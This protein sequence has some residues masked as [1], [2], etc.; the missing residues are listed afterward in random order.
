MDE[1]RKLIVARAAETGADLANLSRKLGRN[2]AYLH[3]FVRRGSPR[4]LPENIRGKLAAMLGVEEAALRQQEEPSSA[5]A[6]QSLPE[7]VQRNA[8][9]GRPLSLDHLIPLYGQAAGGRD[10]AF[11]LNGNKV[12]DILAPPALAGVRNAYA[13]YVVGDSMVP[14]YFSGE[15][16]FVN[17]RAPVR[18]GDFVV[19][20]IAADEGEPP[21]AFVK[22]FAGQ[23]ARTLRLEQLN[24]KKTITFPNARV[25]SIHRI[26]M[27]GEG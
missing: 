11:V 3:Q 16:V 2:H 21:H 22:R 6:L 24:P 5:M 27:G 18:K 9:I 23:D 7:P 8:A 13:V 26:V 10:G 19:V 15:T 1:V 4:E 12:A 20:Q 25:V 17:P 14:R